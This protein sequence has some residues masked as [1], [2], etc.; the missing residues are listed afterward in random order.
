[1][2][3][4]GWLLYQTPVRG[5]FSRIILAGFFGVIGYWIRQDHLIVIAMHSYFLL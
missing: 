1:M 4:A 2:I 5:V 3:L